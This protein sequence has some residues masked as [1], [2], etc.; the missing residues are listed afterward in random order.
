[1]DDLAKLVDAVSAAEV[2]AKL[3]ETREVFDLADNVAPGDL[4]WA[5]RVAVGLDHLARDFALDGLT[6]YYRGLDGNPFERLSAGLILGN[7]LLTARG[8][9]ASGEGDL[10]TCLAMMMMDRFGAGGSYTEF[11]AMDFKDD[12][13]L[14]GHD[15]PGHIAIS[16]R[17][18]ILRRLDLYHGKRGYGVSVE[19]K[20]KTGPITIV[21]VTQDADGRLKMLGAEGDSLPG[22]ILRIGNTN[23]RLRFNLPPAQ[24]V[25]RWCEQGPTH[26]C[27]LGVGHRLPEFRKLS[28]VLHIPL[29]IVGENQ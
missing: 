12:F 22:P 2:R 13:V 9:P 26:H 20:V 14:M 23:S 27:A 16:D 10:K 11:Y 25:N 7:S 5:A 3:D 8:I 15:G 17:K 28:R 1:M 21:C 29:A 19:F 24:F 18:P 4:D 6:Y